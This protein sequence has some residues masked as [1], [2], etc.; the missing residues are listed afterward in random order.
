MAEEAAS[1]LSEAER[2]CLDQ[3]NFHLDVSDIFS[4]LQIAWGVLATVAALGV[5][6]GYAAISLEWLPFI[7]G[8][9]LVFGAT[10]LFV[11]SLKRSVAYGN[12][13]NK[14]LLSILLA[15]LEFQSN[16]ANSK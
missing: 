3:V 4:T 10:L 16:A 5:A 9:A 14:Q 7:P 12:E 2:E 1:A 13:V 15:T 11:L 8:F 6:M